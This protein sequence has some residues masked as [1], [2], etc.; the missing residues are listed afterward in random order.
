MLTVLTIAL[1]VL[2]ALAG[3]SAPQN[4]PTPQRVSSRSPH[5]PLAIPCDNCH[6]LSSWKPIR[7]V[8]EFDHSRTSF[9]LRGMHAG[10]TCT[11]CHVSQ[12]FSNAGTT[13]ATSH[14]DIHR[15]Q[16]G[17]RCEQCHTEKGWTVSIQS[18]QNHQNRFPLVGAHAVVEC[19]ACHR[20]GAT[21][22]F[23]GLSTD[24][25]SCHV[26]DF[27]SAKAPDHQAF[28]TSCQSC[29]SM[30]SWA[31][32]SFDHLKFTGFALT[33]AHTTLDCATCHVGGRFQGTPAN[34]YGCHA[35]EYNTTSNPNHAQAG[36]PTDCQTCHST[37]SWSGATFDHNA[38]TSFPLTGAHVSVACTTCHVNGQFAGTPQNCIGCHQQDYNGTSN[39]NH[40][41]AGFPT[42]CQNC[43]TTT[44][45][46]GAQFNHNTMTSFP[47]TGAHVSVACTTCHVNGQFAG[48]AS[49][50]I[51]C[52]QQD[53][54][55][56]T[57][58][59]HV[60]AGF[61]TDCTTCHST[62]TWTG[63]TFNHS[64]TAF[65]LTGAHVSVACATCH[66]NG[67]F[68]GLGTACVT[69]HL[70]DFNGAT[71]PNHVQAG[72][73]QQCNVCHNTSVWQPATFNHDTTGFPLTG[74][75]VSV[76]C[77]DCHLNGNYTTTPT[78]CY[79][80]HTP[81]YQNTTDPN[82]AAAAFPTTCQTC[83]TTTQWTGATFNHTDFPIYS[84]THQGKWTTC[85]DCHVNS[86]NYTQFSC[87]TCHQ[88]SAANTNPAHNGVRGYVYN[89]TSCYSC[90]PQGR[91]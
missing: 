70:G 68:A 34:C 64:Q 31:G 86:S 80:C 84:G 4:R 11:Q 71:N 79:S 57:N 61:P 46:S 2:L 33:G 18:I 81:E 53:F 87:I 1:Q 36:F 78:A 7:S 6:T 59:N 69:C 28:P 43:H 8:P 45:W 83:H 25:L 75:H 14:A 72:F 44:T 26:A 52:H 89:G 17:G 56:T 76:T 13:C 16:F 51:G 82:H 88:H 9:P 12:V 38:F 74:A 58:P 32:A 30:N 23:T 67:Q 41:Q 54:N 35:T 47:L 10:V 15:G 91:N 55:G 22:Q 20:G 77:A 49:T 27:Q 48:T 5:G 37:A 60:Q 85:A 24:C 50:C 62:V 90:H 29:H 19:E 65:P 66:V 63:A 21:S 73:P 42:T 40:V 39:P 3:G